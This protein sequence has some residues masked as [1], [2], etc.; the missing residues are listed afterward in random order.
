MHEVYVD[1]R[2]MPSFTS[3]ISDDVRR[4]SPGRHPMTLP[5]PPLIPLFDDVVPDRVMC[6][7]HSAQE[8]NHKRMDFRLRFAAASRI[9]PAPLFT[10]A[11]SVARNPNGL[12]SEGISDSSQ[13]PMIRDDDNRRWIQIDTASPLPLLPD[14][15]GKENRD[16]KN[17]KPM[18]RMRPSH[19]CR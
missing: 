3:N 11:V 4:K 17:Y 7:M 8:D 12:P 13:Q 18:L 9:L 15:E 10:P 5:A 2:V 6:S 19:G 14:T 1:S 16:S